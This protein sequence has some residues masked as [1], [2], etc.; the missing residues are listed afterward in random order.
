MIAGWKLPGPR[1]RSPERR[2]SSRPFTAALGLLLALL[3][4]AACEQG[5]A[6][7]ASGSG[8][9]TPGA[10]D[11]VVVTIKAAAD[12]VTGGNP[13]EFRVEANPAPRADLTVKVKVAPDA[14]DGCELRQAPESVTI[15]AGK[16]SAPLA[17]PTVG[18]AVAASGCAVTATIEDGEGYQ[19]GAADG[20]SASVK[21]TPAVPVV[22]VTADAASV[23]AGSPVSFTLTASPPPASDLTVN[24]SWSDPRPLLAATPSRAVTIRASTPTAAL[25][26]DTV[27]GADGSVTVTV[28][29]GSGY[30]VGSSA[31]ATV[32]VTDAGTAGPTSPGGGGS[33]PTPP[34]PSGLPVVGITSDTDGGKV[35]EGE[36][37]KYKLWANPKPASSL[38]VTLS[39]TGD[40]GRLSSP[41][42]NTRTIP[43]D[44]GPDVSVFY[45]FSEGTATNKDG[46]SSVTVEVVA[47]SGYEVVEGNARHATLSIID[48]D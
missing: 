45:R 8:S 47:G 15:A 7:T 31:T 35:T 19:V 38:T 11:S 28:D 22:T 18:V 14:P 44:S 1:R 23:T 25:T 16:T 29:A 20:A 33:A 12:S 9:A 5:V 13:L 39:W 27:D 24:V 48:D 41:P 43:K 6:P 40:T 37:L 2:T 32:A 30:T 3:T 34:S 46:N 21:L 36:P 17:V 42:K 26:A 10:Q 4:L